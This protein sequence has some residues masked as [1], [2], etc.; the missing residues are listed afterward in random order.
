[1]PFYRFFTRAREP[2]NSYTHFIGVLLALA[3]IPL[4]VLLYLWKG[5]GDPVRLLAALIFCVSALALYTTSCFYH[6]YTGSDAAIFRLR[7]LDHS[8][9]Y[10]LIAGSYTPMLMTFYPRREALLFC[11]I[12]WAVAAVGICV[13]VFWFTLP[14]WVSTAIYLIMGWS[15]LFDLGPLTRMPA[16]AIALL[17]AG[18]ISYTVGGVIYG[19]KK[20]NLFRRFGFHELFHCF[21]MLG[22][23]LHYLVVALYI[24]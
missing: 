3:G 8:M 18:G 20:P 11:G 1:M 15:I 13:K 9:I 6:Y 4:S 2:M 10:V 14:R 23:V 21:V 16:P 19:L 22:R 17:A 24:L 7:K 5:T 12:L